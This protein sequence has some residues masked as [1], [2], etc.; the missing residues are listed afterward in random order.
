MSGRLP[1]MERA[2]IFCYRSS[3]DKAKALSLIVH[4]ADI[5]H[6]AKEWNLHYRWTSQLIEEFFLQVSGLA[7]ECAC[8]RACVR[9]CMSRLLSL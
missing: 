2:L 3:I 4:C 9:A 8:V 6:P 7:C 1:P 5:S